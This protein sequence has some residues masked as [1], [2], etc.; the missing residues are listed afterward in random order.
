MLGVCGINAFLNFQIFE[1]FDRTSGYGYMHRR[2]TQD[3]WEGEDTLLL[4]II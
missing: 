2:D 1:I 3:V 4:L